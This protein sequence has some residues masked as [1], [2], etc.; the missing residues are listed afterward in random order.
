LYVWG[1]ARVDGKAKVISQIYLGS[2]EKVAALAGSQAQELSELK[3]EGFGAL[4]VA[5][6]IDQG[7]DL[8]TI[9]DDVVS[10]AE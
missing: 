2:P 8:C 5:N 10:R 4:W 1:I 7:I 9:V 3:V 6:E